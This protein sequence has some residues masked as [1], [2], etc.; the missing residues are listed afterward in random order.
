[1]ASRLDVLV[2]GAEDQISPPRR[3]AAPG[4][5]ERCVEIPAPGYLAPLEQPLAVC[6]ALAEFLESLG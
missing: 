4:R 2:V 3:H 1:M 6:R 5:G